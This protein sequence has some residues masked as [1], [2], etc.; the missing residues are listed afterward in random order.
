MTTTY[1]RRRSGA[2]DDCGDSIGSEEGAA[3]ALSDRRHAQ[4]LLQ[5]V[6]GDGIA[7][8]ADT[9]EQYAQLKAAGQLELLSSPEWLDVR[10]KMRQKAPRSLWKFIAAAARM[11]LIASPAV[12]FSRLRSNR[13]SFF[14]CPMLGFDCGAAFHPSPERRGVRPLRRLS[15]C[16]V[17][18][19]VVVAA[20]AHVH[21]HF[22]DLLPIKFSTCFICAASVW[23]S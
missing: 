18:C 19:L 17:A 7:A 14:R 10:R 2:S 21:M 23:P 9:P 16:T 15:T 3:G 13:C 6:E 4:Q 22:T 1:P 11:A 8:G 12:P 5:R 20:I